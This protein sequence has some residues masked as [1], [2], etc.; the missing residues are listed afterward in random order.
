MFFDQSYNEY[1][2]NSYKS[3]LISIGITVALFALAIIF[4]AI[5]DYIYLIK[6]HREYDKWLNR[7]DKN[8]NP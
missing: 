3:A 4:F 2:G 7:K 1:I 8:E 6:Q 5:K